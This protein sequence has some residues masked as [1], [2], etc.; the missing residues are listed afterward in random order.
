MS[1]RG[2]YVF[3]SAAAAEVRRMSIIPI[4]RW[5]RSGHDYVACVRPSVAWEVAT[6]YG[7]L[8]LPSTR[9]QFQSM[10]VRGSVELLAGGH[11]ECG[12]TSGGG[13]AWVPEL[14]D[15]KDFMTKR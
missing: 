12:A 3:G 5:R 6:Q 10:M 9:W 2:K 14:F 11:R 1:S 15:V 4:R 8:R 7:S 13:V